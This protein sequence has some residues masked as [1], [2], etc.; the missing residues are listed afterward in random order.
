MAHR[1]KKHDVDTEKIGFSL[2]T[3]KLK[4]VTS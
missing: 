2:A 1:P 4:I 3:H